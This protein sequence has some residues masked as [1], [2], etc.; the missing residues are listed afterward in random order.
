MNPEEIKPDINTS[1]PEPSQVPPTPQ[2]IPNSETSP[3]TQPSAGVTV[4]SPQKGKGG[5][6]KVLLLVLVLLLLAGGAYAY[7]KLVLHKA[8]PVT[9]T[10]VVKKDIPLVT[11]GYQIYGSDNSLY[12]AATLLDPNYDVNQQ[13]FEGLVQFKNIN[14]IKPNLATSWTNPDDN[15]W[16]FKLLPNVKFHTGN[17]MTAADVKYSL[18]NF[19]TSDYGKVYNDTIKSVE[20]VNDNEVK[21]STV[22]PDP[23][24]LN[25]LAF[26]YI[27]DSKST[28]KNDA[29]N[30][31]GPYTLKPGTTPS[32]KELDLV[33][34][35]GW[36]GGRPTTRAIN[37]KVYD[38]EAAQIAAAQKGEINFVADVFE[39][40]N[41]TTLSKS[42]SFQD[43]SFQHIGESVLR[44]NSKKAGSPLADKRVRQALYDSLDQASILKARGIDAVVVNQ[45]VP[46]D[47][48]GY[49]PDIPAHKRDVAAAIQLL[50][51]AGYPNGLTI[52]LVN[53][54]NPNNHVPD[55]IAKEAKEAGITIT[56]KPYDDLTKEEADIAAGKMQV[57]G[58]SINTTLLDA[59]DGYPV[60]NMD[61]DYSNPTVKALLAQANS[62]ID[63]AK[64]LKILQDL[65][66][67]LVD[68]VALIPLYSRVQHFYADP[69]FVLTRDRGGVAFGGN[70]ATAYAK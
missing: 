59:S 30:G 2:V 61:Q 35:D 57:F 33:A 68:D 69:T 14:Q 24:L 26:L 7:Y 1:Q 67:A 55:E 31:T 37:F 38:G 65:S 54:A 29:A 51:D 25:K 66:K 45:I 22:S 16:D 4:S 19:K 49:N 60:A 44:I 58:Y 42:A 10:A 5:L 43:I 13:I 18:E 63:P 48:P 21:V 3:S 27:I 40:D 46:K 8:K 39:K 28:L 23:L 9:Q 47:V 6:M 50:K 70:F 64:R 56:F 32:E 11:F 20:I 17:V 36:H 62:T 15:T 34:F 53:F 41:Q 12:P 52:E